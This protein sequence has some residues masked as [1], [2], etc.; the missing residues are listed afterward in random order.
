[1]RAAAQT[2]TVSSGATTAGIHASLSLDTTNGTVT[3]TVDEDGGTYT[4][5]VDLY[6]TTGTP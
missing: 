6:A 4:G 3:I 5:E 2:I 1:M